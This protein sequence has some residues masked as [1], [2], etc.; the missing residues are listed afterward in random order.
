MP[1]AREGKRMRGG[2]P[3]E[4]GGFTRLVRGG[5]GI[6]SENIFELS[7]PVCVLMHF[8]SFCGTEFQ[9]FQVKKF[10]T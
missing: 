1:K 10:Y 2:F 7:T 6:S 3:P 5:S 4:R 8:G 9:S